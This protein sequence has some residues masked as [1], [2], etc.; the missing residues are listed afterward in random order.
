MRSLYIRTH[1]KKLLKDKRPHLSDSSITTYTNIVLRIQRELGQPTDDELEDYLDKFPATQARN[2]ITPLMI[3]YEDSQRH[4]RLFEKYNLKAV[5]QLDAQ[6]L[7]ASEQQNW[8]SKRSMRDALR[9]L[10]KDCEIH[11]VFRGIST[12]KNW[13]LRQSYVLWSVHYEC[14][15]R[16]LLGDCRVVASKRDVDAKANYYVP[17]ENSF[18]I[19]IFKTA[20]AFKRNGHELPIVHKMRPK[21]A[22]LIERHVANR[23]GV[24]TTFLFCGINGRPLSKSSYSNVLTG[25]TKK[26]L[27]K[28]I[29]S[30]LWRHI[31]LT[32]WSR[33]APTLKE[34][35]RVAH[36]FHQISLITQ[37]R[38]VRPEA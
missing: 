4:R 34:R 5:D 28:R 23:D 30:S 38:Y 19:S 35:K 33:G 17:R 15:W 25:M 32:D 12:E 11:K 24:A 8:I 21:L 9:R 14:P 31:W 26:Y 3:L 27:N 1:L 36:L 7:S 29:G 18:Y 2:M 37:M 16:N 10:K 22:A 6:R 13:R 20:R